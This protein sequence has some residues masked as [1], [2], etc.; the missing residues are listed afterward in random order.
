MSELTSDY[1]MGAQVLVDFLRKQWFFASFE[2][3][4]LERL[5]QGALLGFYPK[6]TI[7]LT[8]DVSEVNNLFLIERGA[9]KLYRKESGE[10]SSL[11]D[12]RGE[13]GLVGVA[14][15]LSKAKASHTV[16][17]VEDTFCYLLD[18][19]QFLEFARTNPT[20]AENYYRNLSINLVG[21]TYCE[22]R[23]EVVKDSLAEG[24]ALASIP[25]SEALK[26]IP[27]IIDI[28]ETIHRAAQR[29]AQS[30][31]SVILV[32][33]PNRGVVG[34]VSDRDIRTRVV[35][36]RADY[37]QPIGSIM[38]PNPA[39]IEAGASCLDAVIR[40]SSD[41]IHHLVVRRGLET[42]GV[43]SAQD[44][45][46]SQEMSPIVLLE[47]IDRQTDFESIYSLAK[48]T[49]RLLRRLV[50]SGAKANDVTRII[51]VINDHLVGKLLS[52]L[53]ETLG[54]PP[55]PF[56]WL[57]MGSEGRME[58]T[59]RTDQDNAILYEDPD[60]S[61]ESSKASKLY[62]RFL[63][64]QMIPHL[65]ECGFPLCKGGYM[66]SKTLWRKPFS[67][68]TGYF[69]EWMSTA[70]Q[71]VMLNAKIF[72][73]FRRGHGSQELADR[74]RDHVM[75]RILRNRFFVNHLAKDSLT[76]KPPLSFLRNFIVER[77]GEHKNRLDIK[78][79]GLVP[80]VDFARA[81]ALKHGIRE[82]NTNSRLLALSSIPEVDQ[83]ICSEIL[84]AYEFLMS[85]RLVHQLR[86]VQQGMEPNNF[87]DPADL[88]DLEK[89]TL[90]GAF[91]VISRMQTY[92][93]RI[94]VE[95]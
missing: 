2:R 10:E 95:I 17:A 25:V 77:D 58:Q 45:L 16:E 20:F 34:L 35:A 61:W 18:K 59:L 8:Q 4:V 94:R 93:A 54:P 28:S 82:T 88:T 73:D 21:Q 9:L 64:N 42:I 5:C 65:V 33:E 40:M 56:T 67:V 13:G 24:F 92:M 78:M 53:Q 11:S 55:V 29:M 23:A 70:D 66:A 91:G 37:D 6:G 27:E 90:K 39:T 72:L 41:D 15:I 79:R 19:G 69:D 51:A 43:V 75:E 57:V 83:E 84:S 68:W 49:P 74:L 87:V 26:R 89:Q 85:L 50:E 62:F 38:T 52:L 63:G 3:D 80:V 7:I 81:M 22:L 14:S 71:Y 36:C 86:M 30:D 47:E 1:Q 12:Y 46:A 60:P 31:T 48:K 44:I 32:N 76:I